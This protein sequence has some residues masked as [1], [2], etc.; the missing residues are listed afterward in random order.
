M[1]A[2]GS[3]FSKLG[4]EPITSPTRST[5]SARFQMWPGAQWVTWIICRKGHYGRRRPEEPAAI[6]ETLCKMRNCHKYPGG[7]TSSKPSQLPLSKAGTVFQQMGRCCPTQCR[8]A[9]VIIAEKLAVGL[10]AHFF[11]ALQDLC[12][13]QHS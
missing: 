11:P 1:R 8:V 13:A 4:E 2:N 6:A 10:H 5:G 7:I 9:P 12:L 3:E